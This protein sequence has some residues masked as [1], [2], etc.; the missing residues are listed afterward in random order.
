M[1]WLFLSVIGFLLT[2]VEI[3]LIFL[4]QSC[5]RR[6]ERFRNKRRTPTVEPGILLRGLR[7]RRNCKWMIVSLVFAL[8]IGF[9]ILAVL[10]VRS[11]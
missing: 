1:N 2:V 8:N 7:Y 5:S 6:L 4:A 9:L 3:G 10:F 11:R